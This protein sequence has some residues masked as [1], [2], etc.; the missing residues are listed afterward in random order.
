MKCPNCGNPDLEI[1]D[2]KWF[3]CTRCRQKVMAPLTTESVEKGLDFDQILK[4]IVRIETDEGTGTGFIISKSGH[5]MT[6]SHVMN[7]DMFAYGTIG[8]ATSKVELEVIYDGA[9]HDLD[10][11]ILQIIDGEIQMPLTF[12]KKPPTIGE[13]IYTIGNPKNVGISV[14]KGSISRMT[15]KTHQLDLTVNPG[16]SGGPVIDVFGNVV[17]VIS[18]LIKDLQGMGFSI[19]TEVI[20]AF[21]KKSNV[22]LED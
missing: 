16:N 18:F 8:D 17:G 3:K 13:T 2:D 19:P 4:P 20:Q 10:L 11:C 12:R 15:E 22:R 5:I 6:N 9:E 7:G 1:I 14:S 21:I